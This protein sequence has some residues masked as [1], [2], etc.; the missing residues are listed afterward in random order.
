[1]KTEKDAAKASVRIGTYALSIAYALVM[2]GAGANPALAQHPHPQPWPGMSQQSISADGITTYVKTPAGVEPAGNQLPYVESNIYDSAGA[3]MANTLPSTPSVAFNLI[4]GPVVIGNIDKTSP[5]DDLQQVLKGVQ[6][7]AQNGILDTKRIQFGLDIL[8][9]NPISNRIY[10]G[11]AMLHYT[12]PERIKT[13]QPI[14]DSQG[15]TIGGNVNIHQIWFD[16]HIES[17]TALLDPSAVQ[18]VPFTVT[19]T[20]DV[21]NGGADDFA[22]FMMCFDVPSPMM[23]GML[24]PHVAMDSTFYPMNDGQRF[25]IKVKYPMGSYFNLT[26]HWGWRLH[27][28]KVQVT[29]NALKVAGPMTLVQWETSVFGTAPRSSEDTKLAAIAKIGELSPAKR[30]WQDLRAARTATPQQ[31]VA[32]MTDALLSFNDWRDRTKLPRGVQ[33]DP[34][35]DVTLFYVN[36]TIYANTTTFDNWNGPGSVFRAT[37]LNGDHFVHG[38]MNVDFGGSRGWE[39]VYEFAGGPGGS[40]S[41]GRVYWWVTAGG[42]MGGINVPPVA[43][44]G[45]PGMHKVQIELNFYA[46]ERIKLYQFDPFHH[47]VA[48]YS[49]H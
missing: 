6:D 14:F 36:N 40:H 16:N 38:Y 26:Y 39:N 17:D 37:L 43:A 1:M 46:P 29:E 15:H 2:L 31:V 24:P 11:F 23:P 21:L 20:I 13:V 27:P 33:A 48:V 18:G 3:N 49:L 32:L 9:G 34:N 30:M 8:E 45:T 7:A 22:P 25:V 12:G 10:S 44:N 47:D 4:Q 19:Y 5:T 42:P 28:P 41:F 35:A